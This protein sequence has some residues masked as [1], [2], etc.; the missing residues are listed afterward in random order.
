[1]HYVCIHGATTYPYKK[2]VIFCI[3][4]GKYVYAVF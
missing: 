2:L 1:L 3:Y 4:S